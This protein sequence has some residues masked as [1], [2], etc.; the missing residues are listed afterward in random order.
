MRPHMDRVVV[1]GHYFST[2]LG[3]DQPKSFQALWLPMRAPQLP[4]IVARAASPAF[5]QATLSETGAHRTV[6]CSRGFHPNPI[7]PIPSHIPS[8]PSI[9]PLHAPGGI[10]SPSF[11]CVPGAPAP[12]PL[13]PLVCLLDHR[14]NV[15]Y[16]SSQ[17]K[18]PSLA[19]VPKWD[20]ASSFPCDHSRC[21]SS[22]L[23][24]SLVPNHEKR[25]SGHGS[26][27]RLACHHRGTR[28]AQWDTGEGRRERQWDY[29]H[30]SAPQRSRMS[31]LRA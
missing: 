19:S 11:R 12:A 15:G 6:A 24:A 9:H 31:A 20:P 29:D 23:S 4:G 22:L 14:G 26:C 8:H 18:S 2:Y 30:D 3:T 21:R 25:W 17:V 5:I 13:A 16:S 27:V 1:S 7:H 28:A 10:S